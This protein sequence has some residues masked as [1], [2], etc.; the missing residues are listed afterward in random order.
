MNQLKKQR[1]LV[2]CP[3]RGTYNKPELG[4]LKRLHHD[5]QNL[6]LT[7]D[8]C[9][10]ARGQVSIA[11]LDA[12][13]RYNMAKHTAGENASSL[14]YACAAGDFH[15]INTDKYEIVAVTGNSMGWYIALAIANALN[16]KNSIE[17]INTMGSMMTDGVIGGQLIYPVMDQN[18]HLQKALIEQLQDRLSEVNLI[19]DAC[20][21]VSIKLGG[22]YVIAGNESGLNELEMRLDRIDDT[23]PMR[24]F[25]H[26]AFHSPLLRDTSSQAR[27]QLGIQMF[28]SPTLP[29]IDGQGKIWQPY[30]TDPQALR[31]YTLGPQVVETYDFSKAIEVALKEFAPEKVIVL[32]PGATLGGAIGQCM[33][34]HRYTDMGCKADFIDR[35]KQD[36]VLL[37]MGMEEQRELVIG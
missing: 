14:I 30:S 12:M 35:Q 9:R 18:W 8:A 19:K 22:Y 7:I 33:I 1:A 13:S 27:Q 6:L 25:N 29:L 2:V 32:G 36:P 20:V 5:K 31:E 15:D 3:G 23:Y 34:E 17:L 24:L 26:A 11:E 28:E 10:Q 16:A 21:Y 37:A 4:Y